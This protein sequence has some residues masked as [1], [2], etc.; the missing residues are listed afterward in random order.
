MKITIALALLISATL[1]ANMAP[2]GFKPFVQTYFI[3]TGTYLGKGIQ[4]ALAAGF[5]I[6]YSIELNEQFA[7][8]A[9]T[10]F[11]HNQNVHIINGN[12]GDMLYE[13]IKDINEPVTFWLD[14]HNGTYDPYGENCPVLRELDQIKKHHIKTHTILIDDMH[15]AGTNLFDFITKEEIIAKIKEINPA[16]EIFYIPGGDAGEY[17]ENVMVAI[18]PS[19]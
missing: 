17:P 16:Y 7:N 11:A 15:C 1:N 3:E 13:V 10:K 19:A 6:I 18:V 12:S 2:G 5:E 9:R 14:G 4:Q 8:K